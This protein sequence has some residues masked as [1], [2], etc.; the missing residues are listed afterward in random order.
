MRDV[1]L[2]ADEPLRPFGSAADIEHLLVGREPF[3][4]HFAHRF[5][6]EALRLFAGELQEGFAIVESQA[7]HEA[8]DVGLA[9]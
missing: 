5:V 7:L 4:V 6:P 1:E 3:D 2:A 8:P 9:D